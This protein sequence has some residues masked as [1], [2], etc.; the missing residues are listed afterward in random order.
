MLL[1]VIYSVAAWFSLFWINGILSVELAPGGWLL[2]HNIWSGF[3]NPSFWP[4]LLYRTIAA[5]AIAALAAFVVI[6]VA[7]PLDRRG[8]CELTDRT[9]SCFC[10]HGLDALPGNLVLGEHAPGQP[11]VG[12]GGKRGDDDVHDNRG[13]SV[14]LD[15][16]LCPGGVLVFQTLHQRLHGRVLL[17][18]IALA[19]TAGGEFVGEGVRKPY[20]IRQVLYSNSLRP[21]ELV[22]LRKT[23]SVADDPY[24]LR[25]GLTCPSVQLGN[26]QGL[27]L[28][29]QR[30]VATTGPTA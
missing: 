11:I 18:A 14:A 29:L 19:A 25:D 17:C 26:C 21:D 30:C 9:P 1:L 3:F 24:P 8:P 22:R 13:W 27:P 12:A 15:R 16:R 28:P 5:M 7:S 10:A 6:N 2:T 23:G 4:L 20:S